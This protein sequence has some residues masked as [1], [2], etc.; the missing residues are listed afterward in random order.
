MQKV[1]IIAYFFPPCNLTASQRPYAWAKY[2]PDFG[3][4][5]VVLTRNW[6]VPIRTNLDMSRDAGTADRIENADGFSTRYLKYKGTLR[7]RFFVQTG[8]HQWTLMRKA[9]T[10]LELVQQNFYV[11]HLPYSNIYLKARELLRQEKTIRKLII[12]ANPF[13]SFHFGY[14]LKKEFPHIQWVADYR[15]DWTTTEL[16]AQKPLLQK[17]ISFLEQ[18]SEKKWVSNAACITSISEYY[19]QKIS[20][21]VR[22]PG[23]VVYNGFSEDI[24]SAN[25]LSVTS[26]EF[27]INY[28]GSLYDTQP[29]EIFL[30]AY[31]SIREKFEGRMKITLQF[32]GLAYDKKQEAR[33]KGLLAGADENVH[34]SERMSKEEALQ[35]QQ[36]A[37]LMLMFGHSGL[38]GISSSKIYDYIGLRKKVLLVCNDHDILEQL[39]VRSRLGI[40]AD[41]EEEIVRAVSFEIENFIAQPNATVEADLDFIR[42]LSRK[43]QVKRLA[44]ILSGL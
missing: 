43:N 7:D 28:T 38:K 13:V 12:T 8:H 32:P 35:W 30:N 23:Y 4:R 27:V 1:L 20:A 26:G 18:R 19:A 9:L 33:V 25:P 40:F 6:D 5:P 17:F 29:V 2:L 21:H 42:S 11:R 41:T 15:D 36:R 3:Y 37:N 16:T 24:E 22:K 34:I 10:F 39:L 14:L 44:E 31:K